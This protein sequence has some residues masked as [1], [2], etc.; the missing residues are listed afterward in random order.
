MKD[1]DTIY[2]F[3]CFS[4]NTVGSYDGAMHDLGKLLDWM[5][6]STREYCEEYDKYLREKPWPVFQRIPAAG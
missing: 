6:E 2:E 4:R 1:F 5:Y 3:N